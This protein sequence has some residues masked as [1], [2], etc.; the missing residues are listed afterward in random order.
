MREQLYLPK[1]GMDA[2]GDVSPRHLVPALAYAAQDNMIGYAGANFCK[3]L[4]KLHAG[5][6][7]TVPGECPAIRAPGA[8]ANATFILPWH[9]DRAKNI[10]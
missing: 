10:R 8:I 2:E 7:R 9:N 4:Q 6:L 1:N 5:A 3:R